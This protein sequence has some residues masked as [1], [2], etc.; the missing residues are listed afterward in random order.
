MTSLTAADPVSVLVLLGTRP[1][2]IKLAPAIV[3]LR[4]VDR[5]GVE[6]LC[7]G[8]HADLLDE[9]PETFGFECDYDLG[10]FD[11]GQSLGALTGRIATRIDQHLLQHR[12]ELLMVQGDTTSTFVGALLAHYHGVRCAHVEA[13]LRTNDL[14]NPFPEEAN[15]RLASVL[16]DLHFAPTEGNRAN[17][18]SEG[19][20]ED[21]IVVTGNT[22]IDAL[23]LALERPARGAAPEV[24][25]ILAGD[26]PVILVT[27]HRRESWGDE[28]A[29][30]AV[31]LS[32]AAAERPEWLV[33][34]PVHPN[35]IVRDAFAPLQRMENVRLLEPVPYGAFV[36]LMRQ[37]GLI[38]TDS[39]GIQEEAPSLDRPVLV[40]R[41]VT[42]RPEAIEAGAARLV[43]TDAESIGRAV[44]ELIEDR[45]LYESMAAAPNPYGD[46]RA[47][48]RILDGLLWRYR[49][50]GRPADFQCG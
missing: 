50:S 41:R 14:A 27:S 37:A 31:G 24:Q 12:P 18:I 28:M 35:P 44:S 16:A 34:F 32:I 23:H 3:A 42:E 36:H 40:M 9:I 19:V 43:G 6:V 47:T 30:I 8:Q 46:G 13:G 21:A 26:R 20:T 49:G 10:A 1:E 45:R 29:Q 38:L 17:L 15:R 33:V 4:E 22:V 2:A 11:A 7:T 48:E 39:G 5:F 25:E